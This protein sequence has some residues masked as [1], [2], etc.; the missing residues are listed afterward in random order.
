MSKEKFLKSVLKVSE[1]R[2]NNIS[3]FGGRIEKALDRFDM[4]SRIINDIY[5]QHLRQ[6]HKPKYKYI[7]VLV[8]YL[9]LIARKIIQ[10]NKMIK[11]P[12]LEQVCKYSY[13]NFVEICK[14]QK[15][16]PCGFDVPTILNDLC[17][18]YLSPGMW[19]DFLQ[20]SEKYDETVFANEVIFTYEESGKEYSFTPSGIRELALKILNIQNRDKVMDLGCGTGGFM[21]TMFDN[22]KLARYTESEYAKDFPG[23]KYYGYEISTEECEIAVLRASLLGVYNIG[24]DFVNIDID[25]QKGF[26]DTNKFNKIFADYPRGLKYLPHNLEAKGKSS[27]WA[28]NNWI[29]KHLIPNGG[30]A[31]AIMSNGSAWNTVDMPIR[32]EFIEAGLIEAVIALPSGI[33]PNTSVATTMIVFSHGNKNIKMV[34]ATKTEVYNIFT[35]KDIEKILTGLNSDTDYSKTVSIT[36]LQNNDYVLSFNRYITPEIKF[37]HSKKLGEL[38]L[39]IKRGLSDIPKHKTSSATNVQ[40]LSLSNIQNGIIDDEL[41]YALFD[42][43]KAQKANLFLK[44]NDLI[45]SKSGQPYKVA[46]ARPHRGQLIIPSGNMYVIELDTKQ[47]SPYYVKAFLESQQGIALLNAHSNHAT[48]INISREELQKIEIPIPSLAVQR[49][50]VKAYLARAD[51]YK[52]YQSKLE[53]VVNRLNSVFDDNYKD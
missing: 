26:C 34:D 43:E 35:D 52:I 40:C 19:G 44:E 24:R 25:Y 8:G 28:F 11:R 27:D 21:T 36:E 20:L 45:V 53:D 31:I 49:K 46:V 9:L 16:Y 3:D 39:S 5:E 14:N 4:H 42:V 29:C 1:L 38:V 50:I 2:Y 15:K 6:T 37:K 7:D 41:P 30:K 33:F 12:T 23:A 10:H 47:V 22:E 51:E 13:N 18:R 48:I 32:K 17:N